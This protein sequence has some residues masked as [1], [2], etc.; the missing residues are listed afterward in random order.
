MLIR[1]ARCGY[2]V[3]RV[4]VDHDV[5][6]EQMMNLTH[7]RPDKKYEY[8]VLNGKDVKENKYNKTLATDGDVIVI[9]PKI[10]GD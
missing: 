2:D 1:I 7:L 5:T 4:E 6:I 3:N 8:V 9:L 10:Q